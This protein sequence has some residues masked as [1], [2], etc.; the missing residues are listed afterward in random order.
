MPNSP[1][2]RSARPRRTRSVPSAADVE[3]RLLREICSA[4]FTPADWNQIEQQLKGYT[5]RQIEHGLVYA[6]AQK[7]A[8]R[9]P[10][11]RREHLPAQA[12]RMGFPDIEWPRYFGDEAGSGRPA[13]LVRIARYVRE[14][15]G[16]NRP[17]RRSRG[18]P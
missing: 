5:W 14:L 10:K 8:I 7:L 16:A 17:H 2:R 3:L 18:C 1:K 15:R 12:T 9:E 6:A 11:L 4:A 13:S